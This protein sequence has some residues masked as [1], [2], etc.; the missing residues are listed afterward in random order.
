MSRIL[1]GGLTVIM[2]FLPPSIFF[3]SIYDG[4]PDLETLCIAGLA[5]FLTVGVGLFNLFQAVSYFL[6]EKRRI[7]TLALKIS[8]VVAPIVIIG[9]SVIYFG[10]KPSATEEDKA[11]FAGNQE[12]FTELVKWAEINTS[13]PIQ[14]CQYSNLPQEFREWT[15]SKTI[16]ICYD[17][18]GD[19][20]AISFYRPESN[21]SFTY[22]T[23]NYI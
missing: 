5:L 23:H 11:F 7:D 8:Y 21:L 20:N 6:N 19:I 15:Q 13:D 14:D 2:T 9:G 22:L 17:H 16:W 10:T 3:L 18:F 4:H 12:K 1:L